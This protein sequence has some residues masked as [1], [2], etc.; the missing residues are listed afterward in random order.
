MVW[1]FFSRFALSSLELVNIVAQ[2]TRFHVKENEDIVGRHYSP[3]EST[4][5][6]IS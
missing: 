2:K 4:L 5:L 1:H 3:T 6:G